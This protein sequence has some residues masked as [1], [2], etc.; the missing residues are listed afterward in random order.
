MSTYLQLSQR[1]RQEAGLS[2]TGP[3]TVTSQTGEMRRI[4]DWVASAW[5]EIQSAH[6]QWNWMRAD[7]SFSTVASQ[8]AYTAAEAGV[9][10]RFRAWELDGMG[11]KTPASNDETELMRMAYFDFRRSYII[12]PQSEARPVAVT[13]LPNRSLALGYTPNA[14]YT[15][16]GEYWKAHQTLTVDADIPE[17]PTDYHEAV[18]YRAL[19]MYARYAAASEVYEDANSKYLFWMNK[20]I[21]EQLPDVTQPEPLA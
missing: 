3:T 14:V 12:G 9:A 16:R 6:N 20:L 11:I 1:L 7:F 5:L 18:L 2:G 4:V 10:S 19:M 15:V 21:H 8:Q 17:M 13:A